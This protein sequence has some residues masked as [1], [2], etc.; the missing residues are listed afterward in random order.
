MKFEPFVKLLGVMDHREQAWKISR[1]NSWE[2]TWNERQLET[3]DVS[4]N[5]MKMYHFH[6]RSSIMVRDLLFMMNP[7]HAWA[8]ATRSQELNHDTLKE[9]SEYDYGQAGIDH[10]ISMLEN[11]AIESEARRVL[12]MSLSTEY[13]VVVDHRTIIGFLRTLEAINCDIYAKYLPLFTEHIPEYELS[14]VKSFY[15]TYAIHSHDYP[16]G[17]S[18]SKGMITAFVKIPLMLAGQFIR[19]QKGKMKSSLFNMTRSLAFQGDMV[20]I[21]ITI[22]EESYRSMIRKRCHWFADWVMWD[23]IVYD[24]IKDM[25]TKEFWDFLPYSKGEDPY[26]MDMIGRVTNPISTTSD[27][28]CP[29][30]CEYPDFVM[31]RHARFGD[32][33]I[34]NKWMDLVDEGYIKYN[35]MNELYKQYEEKL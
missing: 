24:Y 13:S 15:S 27:L 16:N 32:N 7:V 5:S 14:N 1:P 11:G 22:D 33:K 26:F 21:L 17:H 10:F 28:P 34:N 9:S 30:M 23:D 20:S 25:D 29:V 12:P 6:I 4:L 8:R 19:Q 31:Q 3:L 18:V 2:E 35:P